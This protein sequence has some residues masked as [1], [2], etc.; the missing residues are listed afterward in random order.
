MAFDPRFLDELR[1]R[2]NL[3]ELVG[4]RVRLIRRGR[5]FTGLCPFHNEKTPSFTVSEEKQF[6]HC[7]GCG[8][9]GD[10]IGFAMR[11]DGLA[12]PEAVETLAKEAGLEVP[13]TSPEERRRAAQQA[14]LYG[15]MEAAAA[16]F[17]AELRAPRGKPGLDYLRRRG[18]DD[19]AIARWRLGWAPDSRNALRAALTQTRDG[20]KIDE[21]QLIEAGLL[22]KVEGETSYDRFR[23]RVIFPI[24]DARGRIIAFGGRILEEREGVAKYLNS[25]DTPLFHK[26]RVLYG[27]AQA[28][29]ATRKSGR[30]V[31]TEGYTD[32]IAMAR[33]GVEAVAPL[34]TALTETHLELLWKLA[35]EPI[36][37]FDGDAAGRRAASRAL[38]RA[39]PVLAP[40]KSLR[41]ALLPAGED[42]DSLI[43]REGPLAMET[44]L[45]GAVPLDRMVWDLET[46]GTRLDTPERVAGLEK[47]L[48]DRARQIADRKVQEQYLQALRRRVREA[49]WG[50]RARRG[51]KPPPRPQ[52]AGEGARRGVR[53][54]DRRREQLILLTVVNHP[55]L[56][57]EFAESL[58]GI[59]F[60]D[61]ALDRLRSEILNVSAVPA[62][63]SGS[64][65]RQLRDVGAGDTLAEIERPEVRGHGGFAL[66]GTGAETARAGLRQLLAH[67]TRAERQ[68]QIFEAERA[69]VNNPTKENEARW[70]QLKEADTRAENEAFEDEI[71]SLGRAPQTS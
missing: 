65:K 33:A 43:R 16:W 10:A 68:A 6:F 42:P 20:A 67:Y 17:E 28:R 3:A 51:V 45:G 40:G 27:L 49:V 53:P 58:G 50:A 2:V 21:A 62:L 60:S 22:I 39:L 69:W 66:P 38:E 8:A 64:L 48:E 24:S 19:A 37:C 23:G 1:D 57:D 14:T 25:P 59:E 32:V 61:R 35:A 52:D 4:R 30:I 15:V 44:V 13:Q 55:E 63:D 11:I 9:H 47:R 7:F 41:F 12:F 26:G 34:G 46:E 29:E 70:L 18:F 5:E 54:L 31:V 36:L 56:L 71:A